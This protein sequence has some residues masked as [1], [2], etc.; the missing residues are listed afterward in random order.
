MHSLL[1]WLLQEREIEIEKLKKN[2]RFK[3]ERRKH[4]CISLEFFFSL[5]RRR[6]RSSRTN[7]APRFFGLLAQSCH[8]YRCRCR[9]P[10]LSFCVTRSCW[11]VEEVG[12][13]REKRE[14]SSSNT[15]TGL[16]T[17]ASVTRKVISVAIVRK[18]RTW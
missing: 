18:R 17:K 6:I 3:S 13:A 8:R 16:L 9:G 4:C 5:L 14:E 12:K 7:N 2:I 11:L 15:T 1:Q 10:C